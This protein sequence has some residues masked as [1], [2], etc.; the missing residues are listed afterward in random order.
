MV[1]NASGKLGIGTN[2]TNPT[3]DLHILH[4][5]GS[6]SAGDGFT[7][8]NIAGTQSW[9]M[10]VSNLS[11]NLAIYQDLTG[12]MGQFDD[13][14]GNYTPISDR[15]LKKNISTIESVL[16]KINSLNIRRYHFKKQNDDEQTNIGV[17]AQELKEVFP[18]LVKHS[19]DNDLFT[20]DYTSMA[21]LAIKAI[22]EQQEIIDALKKKVEQLENNLKK[23]QNTNEQLSS[24][25]EALAGDVEY[26]KRSVGLDKKAKNDPK[27]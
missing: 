25:L 11:G 10:F 23:E 12:F 13:S 22:Q 24:K 5:N 1:I 4:G 16:P 15:R 7:I 17:I 26:I 9:S 6:P 8:Q 14:N 2:F 18:E 21:P 19:K 3:T 20:V 27:K